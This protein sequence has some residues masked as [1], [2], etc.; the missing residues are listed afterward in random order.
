VAVLN[1][2]ALRERQGD[3]SLLIDRLFQKVDAG[4]GAAAG[5]KKKLSAGAKNV[6]LNHGWPGNV[7]ELQNTLQRMVVWTDGPTIDADEA[8][9]ALISFQRV[10]AP[11]VLN[12]PLG[13]GFDLKK[14]LDEVAVH[15]LRR[16]VE[17]SRG[18]KTEAAN[19]VGLPSYQTLSNWLTRYGLA[20]ES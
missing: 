5:S 2:P 13:D 14:L 3:L 15:Y 1:L 20:P 19:L 7:R 18:N 6:L 10:V 4:N 9:D 12:R 16:A 17:E 11:E 8:R